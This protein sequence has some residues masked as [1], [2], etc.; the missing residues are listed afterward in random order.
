MLF[1]I[2]IIL[3]KFVKLNI[4]SMRLVYKIYI[5]I[6]ISIRC[7]ILCEFYKIVLIFYLLFIIGSLFMMGNCILYILFMDKSNVLV[8]ENSIDYVSV[9]DI[10]DVIEVTDISDYLDY[11]YFINN[12]DVYQEKSLLSQYFDG[13]IKLFRK[14]NICVVDIAC[15]KQEE[16][17]FKYKF[18]LRDS[19]DI[20]KD[21]IKVKSVTTNME[22]LMFKRDQIKVELEVLI[23]ERDQIR[24]Q[25]EDKEK[26]LLDRGVKEKDLRNL[27]RIINEYDSKLNEK[28][29]ENENLRT[30]ISGFLGRNTELA[31]RNDN[32]QR[33]I[34]NLSRENSVLREHILTNINIPINIDINN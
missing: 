11:I 7:Y 25:L 23:S 13:F 34:S 30:Y 8:L 12:V 9:S 1:V 10:S 5:N 2:M 19:T 6:Y 15:V 18:D 33:R 21:F 29:T 4:D 14:D 17:L 28:T 31:T 20:E 24:V 22:V 16:D 32:L 26:L 3:K 27:Q